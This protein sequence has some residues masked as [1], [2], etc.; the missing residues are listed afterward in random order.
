M[1]PRSKNA[2]WHVDNFSKMPGFFY[3]WANPF[4]R[5]NKLQPWYSTRKVGVPTLRGNPVPGWFSCFE[6]QLFWE[7]IDSMVWGVLLTEW[8]FETQK[9]NFSARHPW[10]RKIWSSKAK[11]FSDTPFKNENL[12]LKRA[13]F[14]AR[15]PSKEWH[16]DHTL[17][18]ELQYVLAVF[19]RM[20]CN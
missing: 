8:S 4:L 20:L 2:F 9:R 17:D 14:S 15:L 10:K 19:K 5:S 11:P 12:K 1:G 7:S 13:I 6:I 3:T 18:W 16:V